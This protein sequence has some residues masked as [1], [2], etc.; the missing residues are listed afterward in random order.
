MPRDSR[1]KERAPGKLERKLLCLILARAFPSQ[2]TLALIHRLTNSWKFLPISG[3]SGR[4]NSPYAAP[5][6]LRTAL[7]PLLSPA[8]RTMPVVPP[9]LHVGEA[10]SLALCWVGDVLLKSSTP[11]GRG[12]KRTGTSDSSLPMR[13]VWA[14]SFWG[15]EGRGTV[16]YLNGAAIGQVVLSLLRL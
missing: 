2:E 10:T 16:A 9:P 3:D 6:W 8:S 14:Q 12:C 11:P 1:N 5:K 7:T 13:S 4:G 15:P